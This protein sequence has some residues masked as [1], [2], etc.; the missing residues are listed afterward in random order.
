MKIYFRNQSMW[1]LF[2][3]KQ[4]FSQSNLGKEVQIQTVW[5]VY[6]AV[7]TGDLIT[8]NNK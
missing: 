5:D 8:L 2:K 6:K 7:M 4:I 3:K 1:N